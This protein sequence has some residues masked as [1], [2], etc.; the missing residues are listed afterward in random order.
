M[1]FILFQL[2]RLYWKRLNTFY[3]VVAMSE[4]NYKERKLRSKVK[5]NLNE[6]CKE[7]CKIVNARDKSEE[8]DPNEITAR[9]ANVCQKAERQAKE[10]KDNAAFGFIKEY[11]K[12]NRIF[13]ENIDHIRKIYENTMGEKIELKLYFVRIEHPCFHTDLVDNA[14][15]KQAEKS[16]SG[17]V[18]Y[19]DLS[20]GL[21][22]EW[23]KLKG[24]ISGLKDAQDAYIREFFYGDLFKSLEN[25]KDQLGCMRGVEPLYFSEFKY[26]TPPHLNIRIAWNLDKASSGMYYIQTFL[27]KNWETCFYL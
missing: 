25:H 7:V 5:S 16:K 6:G 22:D 12:S 26:D 18:S 15:V 11:G 3:E 13:V 1:N 23:K 24:K 17:G 4:E 14:V 10:R 2:K 8:E 19:V 21:Y 20:I 27:K 9:M